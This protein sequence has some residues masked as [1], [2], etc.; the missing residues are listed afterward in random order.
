MRSQVLI[1]PASK[2]VIKFLQL[3]Q[4]RAGG[5]LWRMH[6]AHLAHQGMLCRQWNARMS[7]DGTRAVQQ[8]S[9][10]V[11]PQREQGQRQQPATP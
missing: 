5:K 7:S 10:L 3:M 2:V 8:Q 11:L 1:R 4:V 9:Y 6:G